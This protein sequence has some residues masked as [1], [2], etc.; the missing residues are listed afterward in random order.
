MK[1]QNKTFSF[2]KSGKYFL[3]FFL[4]LFFLISA[5][6]VLAAGEPTIMSLS[7]VDGATNVA[8]NT[9]LVIQFSEPVYIGAGHIYI[10][11]SEG[12]ILET[13]QVDATS[14]ISGD[15]TDTITIDLYA[16]LDKG[17]EYHVEMEAGVFYDDEFN[18]TQ[19]ISDND[20]WNFSTVLPGTPTEISTCEEFKTSIEADLDGEYILTDDLDCTAEGNG[21]MIDGIFTGTLD[22]NE[23]SIT[24]AIDSS[25]SWETGL[26]SSANRAE[27]KNLTL[28]GS[29]SGKSM[30]GG[31]VGS[32]GADFENCINNAN[33]TSSSSFTGGFVGIG[34]D[35]S[36]SNSKNLGNIICHGWCGGFFG[37]MAGDIT[38][39]RSFNQGNI[40]TS[41]YAGGF[42][43]YYDGN[44]EILESYNSG[45][46]TAIAYDVGGI[47]G[48]G[49]NGSITLSN[50]YNWGNIISDQNADYAIRI[51][52]LVGNAPSS[53]IALEN[54]YNS[55][56]VTGYSYV[57]G[58]VGK[59][60]A[61]ISEV[62]NVFSTGKINGT[63]AG[64]LFGTISGIDDASGLYAYDYPEDSAT[65]C[66]SA[67]T[68][69]C[70]GIKNN[71]NGGTDYFKNRANLPVSAW[72]NSY[73]T[74]VY[75]YYPFLS[76][77]DDLPDPVNP[78]DSS[79]DSSVA[80]RPVIKSW[81]AFKYK[82]KSYCRE[83]LEINILG[84][85]FD[86]DV[87]V[88]IG[89][90]EASSVK[91]KSSQQIVAKFCLDKLLDDKTDHKRK[92]TVK[93]PDAD[94]RKTDKQIDL[95]NV[96]EENQK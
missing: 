62:S 27:I 28:D 29:V 84:H 19:A 16:T 88:M 11:N 68:V 96:L 56:D 66:E 1:K 65:I 61:G 78:S 93:N 69:S 41:D 9:I 52:G 31:F 26:F 48:Y 85:K 79:D 3:V 30:V 13:V 44:I 23:K 42:V 21:I 14:I 38:I 10:K 4:A 89:N 22:G 95:T 15:G 83:R 64:L 75:G 91:R 18:L 58:L 94:E 50:V 81:E 87:N 20:T 60:D 49:R 24:V 80:K 76:W 82:D 33:I 92:I 74:F 35:S 17:T 46:I 2:L 71:G 34:G 32:G 70:D 53:A 6:N 37:T 54:C 12:E 67:D 73:W 90:K 72:S 47:I 55:G 25:K 8:T 36:I 77:Q 7:P 63:N 57:G 59:A 86:K 45:N 51:G 5:K 43:G 39:E 40:T